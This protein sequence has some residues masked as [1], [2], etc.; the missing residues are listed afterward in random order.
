[1]LFRSLLLITA[2]AL[3]TACAPTTELLR[4]SVEG[5]SAQP[6]QRLLV[7]GVS[8]DDAL[9]RRYEQ[10]FVQELTAAGLTGIAS[11]DL[12][13]SIAGLTMPE[14]RDKMQTF[15]DRADAVLHVQ[16][17]TLA[18]EPTWAP[19][20]MPGDS[21]P[22]TRRIAGMN[23]TINQPQDGEV[24]GSQLL[25]ELESN[26]YTLPERRLLWTVLTATRE[27][28]DPAAVARSHARVMIKAMRTRGY[29]AGQP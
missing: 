10:A 22:A 23:I 4:S 24:R 25:V 21:A 16:L 2:F 20:D 11:S 5:R 3:V 29:V 19:T 18:Q 13:P 8:T 26:L 9:R 12:L 27:A 15:S 1:M 7:V 6:A 28:N 17:M 14:I